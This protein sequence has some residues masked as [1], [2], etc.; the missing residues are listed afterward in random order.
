[1][2]DLD[3]L[4]RDIF[5]QGM[6]PE[7]CGYVGIQQR[8]VRS[9]G[10]VIDYDLPIPMRDGVIIR[11]DLYR[12]AG[13]EARVPCLV[14]WSPYGKHSPV[15]WAMFPGSEVDVDK[16]SRYTLVECPDPVVWCAHGYA[17]LCVDPRGTWG[18]E[19][20]FSIQSPQERQDMYDAIEWAAEQ[21]WAT[22]KVGMTGMS[23]FSWSQWQA[24]SMHPPH[25][26][27]IQPYDGLTD[28]YRE[29]AFHGG[30]PN[31]QFMATWGAKK[32]QWGKNLVEDWQKAIE[33][34]PLLDDFWR[35]KQPD[36]ESINIPTYVVSSWTDHGIHTR[37]TIEGFRRIS[38]KNKFL[39]VHGRKKWAR[40]YWPESVKR[41]IAFFDR[42]L[43]GIQN[44]VDTWPRIRIEIRDAFCEGDWRDE[45][46]WPPARTRYETL[47]LNADR[48]AIESALPR[49]ES[50]FEYA[51]ESAEDHAHFTYQFNDE[52]E[53]TGYG[54][55]KLWI[56]TG[57][58]ND[59]DLF[60]AVQK[61]GKD[62][63]VI[64]FPYFTLQND[65]QAAHGWQ[66]LSHRALD[67]ECSTA[68]QPVHRHTFEELVRP[69]E[70]V[71]VEIELWPSSTRFQ[72]G[73]S[74]R[75]IVKGTDIQSY[76]PQT[77]VAGHKS[78]RNRGKH[79]IHTGGRYDSHLLIP[80][81]PKRSA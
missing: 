31:T 20:N 16:L 79:R 45:S 30:I 38:S 9:E 17:L 29:L 18:S 68:W 54:K 76:P 11:A 36:L 34:H 23:Y 44:E 56:S 21:S 27:A 43:K 2:S 7:K 50:I 63:R 78:T 8:Q 26:A 62:G 22:E 75:L 73:E 47:Y 77:F 51:S 19:G 32:T 71:P 3:K 60:V 40:Y 24:A 81:V 5:V 12:P 33:F 4:S 41:Q 37:G 74:M 13:T 65:G 66:R 57:E 70:I 52:T 72:A 25:L 48:S 42:Y 28:A 58:S 6:P 49:N 10:L 67:E 69:G 53:I 1:M 59:A 55:V 39:E 80:V 15:T 64:N 35:S 14:I 46:E 61:L